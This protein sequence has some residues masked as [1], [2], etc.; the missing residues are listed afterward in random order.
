MSMS[1]Q[2]DLTKALSEYCSASK[3]SAASAGSTGGGGGGATGTGSDGEGTGTA[4]GAQAAGATSTGAAAAHG[5]HKNGIVVAGAGI[6]AGFVGVV[7]AL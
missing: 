6:L 4:T 7:A 2:T 1:F 5:P 3:K